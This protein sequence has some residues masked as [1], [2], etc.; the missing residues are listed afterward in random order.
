MVHEE[1]QFLGGQNV[2]EPDLTFFFVTLLCR[3]CGYFSVFRTYIIGKKKL[4]VLFLCTAPLDDV[5]YSTCDRQGTVAMGSSV[6]VEQRVTANTH[7]Y[8]STYLG[9]TVSFYVLC[10][11]TMYE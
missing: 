10:T 2:A 6:G 1:I 7:T 11:V 3:L 4:K 8:V 5:K 9:R